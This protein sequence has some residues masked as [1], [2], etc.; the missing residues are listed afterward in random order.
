MT[1]TIVLPDTPPAPPANATEARAVLDSRLA[2]REWGAK[3]LS[4]DV[5]ANT[6]YREL[7]AK[8]DNPETADTVTVA[9]SGDIGIMPDSDMALLANMAGMLREHGLNERQV[10]E[11]LEGREASQ[12]EVDMA[13]MWKNQNLKSKEFVA[14]WLS[15]EPEAVRQM[16]VANI[17]LTSPLKKADAA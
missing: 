9:M 12:A 15:G 8:A 17:I 6:E 1:D 3:L 2:D 10:R 13:R 16:L 5:A 7:R 11:T 14:R 4:G